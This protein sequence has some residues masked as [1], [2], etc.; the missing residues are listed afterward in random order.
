MLAIFR[1][2]VGSSFFVLSRFVNGVL[3]SDLLFPQQVTPYF[4]ISKSRQEDVMWFSSFSLNTNVFFIFFFNAAYPFCW[5]KEVGH[6]LPLW[7]VVVAV[8]VLQC[9]LQLVQRDSLGPRPF[10]P[11]V[12]WA[13]CSH[14]Q[15]FVS[16]I[17]SNWTCHYLV[18][19]IGLVS[20]SGV[21]RYHLS[22]N[23]FSVIVFN[24]VRMLVLFSVLGF[25][26]CTIFIHFVLQ[27]LP[28]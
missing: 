7:I 14:T 8:D 5:G 15:G 24:P 21:R 17:C 22:S 27:I 23:W 11:C 12:C 19:R 16:L 6:W 25:F 3:G 13:P 4:L 10:A 20:F 26:V 9:R 18:S 1:I 2:L 28:N